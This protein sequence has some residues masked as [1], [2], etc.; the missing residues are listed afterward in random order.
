MM[1][2]CAANDIFGYMYFTAVVIMFLLKNTDDFTTT[3]LDLFTPCRRTG[4]CSPY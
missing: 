4:V 3:S 1:H 2:A